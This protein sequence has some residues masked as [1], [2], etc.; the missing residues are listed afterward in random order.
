MI[1]RVFSRKSILLGAICAVAGVAAL[2]TIT[3]SAQDAGTREAP[4]ERRGGAMNLEGAMKLMERS[5]KAIARQI[6]DPGKDELTLRAI[7]NLQSGAAASKAF[8]PHEVEEKSGDDRTAALAEYRKL[9]LETL[10]LAVQFEEELLAGKRDEARSTLQKIHQ[11]EEDGHKK[12]RPDE[13]H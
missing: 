6:D 9:L 11:M 4:A 1:Q 5:Y 2:G 7:S 12:F 13:D 8:L 10:K 3:A